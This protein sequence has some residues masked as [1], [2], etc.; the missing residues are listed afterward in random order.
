MVWPLHIVCI[1]NPSPRV[2]PWVSRVGPSPRTKDHQH[3]IIS[4]AII[5][6]NDIFG[7]QIHTYV[8][9]YLFCNNNTVG[10]C[11]TYRVS[12][13]ESCKGNWV[14]YFCGSQ[15]PTGNINLK[16]EMTR[17]KCKTKLQLASFH[18][19]G[20]PYGTPC[21]LYIH[22]SLSS[23]LKNTRY[24]KATYNFVHYY[25]ILGRIPFCQYRILYT[26]HTY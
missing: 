18:F 26:I 5:T 20:I 11:I 9:T 19:C 15:D 7:C 16:E 14:M 17:H 8:Y 4:F 13:M 23:L 10:I 25:I 24:N 22:T 12:Y 1:K 3:G 2:G 21:I 6:Y